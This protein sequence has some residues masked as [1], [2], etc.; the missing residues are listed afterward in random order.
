[1]RGHKTPIL[2]S[3]NSFY[4]NTLQ[5]YRAYVISRLPTG[6][7]PTDRGAVSCCAF[8]AQ[9]FRFFAVGRHFVRALRGTNAVE[10][11]TT[12]LSARTSNYTR[13]PLESRLRAEKSRFAC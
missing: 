7:E 11:T 13:T 10:S 9:F 3:R 1:M 12:A 8:S 4:K 2:Q 6:M 5:R